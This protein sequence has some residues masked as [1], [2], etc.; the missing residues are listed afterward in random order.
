M[1]DALPKRHKCFLGSEKNKE[2]KGKKKKRGGVDNTCV[3]MGRKNKYLKKVSCVQKILG[4]ITG[5]L[6]FWD[7]F[8]FL[9]S[10]AFGFYSGFMREIGVYRALYWKIKRTFILSF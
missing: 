10:G 3:W 9:D 8:S 1:E 6:C 7:L 5:V 2:V 4:F